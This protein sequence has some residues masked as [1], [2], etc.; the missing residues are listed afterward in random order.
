[1]KRYLKIIKIIISIGIL[2]FLFNRVE[3][4]VLWEQFR[5]IEIII[6]VFG[7]AILFIQCTLSSFK[8]KVILSI[9]N[10]SV[11][12]LFLLKSYMIGNF[13][14]LFLPSSFGGDLYRI[15]ALKKYS[16][17]Y[18]Q[19]TSSVLFDRI[20]GLFALLSISILSFALFF[21][22]VIDVRIMA[23]YVSAIIVFWVMTTH[24]FI[25]F[26]EKFES[27]LVQFPRRILI[28]FS[29]YRS[30]IPVLLT[31]LGISFFFQSNIVFLNK[32]Y[33]A[34]LNI[35]IGITYLF[36]V[37]PLVYLT[38]ALPISIN[39]LG[40]REGAFVFF[41]NQAG[42]TSEQG[43]AL[44]L[45]VISMR[46]VFAVSVGGS[47]FFVEMIRTRSSEKTQEAIT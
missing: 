13:L 23:I 43:L 1:M 14:S 25:N 37:I 46:Y 9:E 3:V 24:W 7:F 45:L 21:R 4:G 42:F 32:V 12:Y 34:A 28:S 39:G 2:A 31:T 19:N 33:V 5:R 27:K 29:R 8:W 36:M 30:N 17:D 26:F 10:K 41:L 18:L 11:P 22:N 16:T 38:E 20:T 47:L 44:G 6:I 15:Y 40:V 35:D